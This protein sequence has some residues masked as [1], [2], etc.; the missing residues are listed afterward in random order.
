MINRDISSSAAGDISSGVLARDD[1]TPF[2]EPAGAMT[3]AP[4]LPVILSG[5]LG[6]RLWPLSRA[7]MPKQVLSLCG[8]KPMIAAT[9]R[10]LEGITNEPPVVV[11]SEDQ[12]FLVADALG[13][14]ERQIGTLI[15]EPIGRNTAPAITI[16]ALTA[17]ARSPDSILVVQPSDHVM[18][19]LAAFQSTVQQACRIATQQR[20]LVLLGVRPTRAETGYGYIEP[21]EALGNGIAGF[22][23][24]QFVE[25]P[26]AERAAQFMRSES[27]LWNVGIFV[28][29]ARAILEELAHLNPEI[30]DRCRSALA[31][32]KAN[33]STLRLHAESFRGV[34]SISIDHA[35]MEKSN[36]LAVVPL[37]CSWT[38]VGSWAALWDIERKDQHGNVVL[39]D[40]RSVDTQGSYL[41]SEDRLMV[42]LGLRDVV[43]IST[44][45]ALVVADKA[46]CQNIKA[47]VESLRQDGRR[48]VLESTKGY[49]PWG[50][51]ETVTT[52][53][54]FRVKRIVVEPGAQLSLQMHH[55]RA[56]HWV[57]VRG[58]ALVQVNEET[59]LRHE[60][61]S[62]FV[63]I[64]V[65][66]RVANPGKIPLELIEVQVGSYLG[67]D[68]IVRFDD[69]YG[70]S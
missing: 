27:W 4:I 21:G 36:N 57:V 64:G 1:Q 40:V 54:R 59:H 62:V 22:S 16:A 63:P 69:A 7:N 70:R 39:G 45:D 56:E 47:V 13:K 28:F 66:H 53:D 48:E 34:E 18:T 50:T 46:K 38:D 52:G 33:G 10:R 17:A 5:G 37:E 6:T 8:D 51:F 32:S 19:D 55:H 23:V 9:A 20:R 31:Q 35:V 68:D 3:G 11:C 58:T 2:N 12:Q 25:K 60:N 24:K 15:L 65:K 67:E 42:S 43:V 26:D 41:R 61:E 29:T 14:H 49:R 44:S 30:L